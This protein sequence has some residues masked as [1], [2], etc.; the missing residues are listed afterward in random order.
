MEGG[1]G[2]SLPELPMTSNR[3]LVWICLTKQSW[4]W[5]GAGCGLVGPVLSAQ[6]CGAWLAFAL[7]DQNWQL[8]HW[9]PV[10]FTLSTRDRREGVW[11]SQGDHYAACNVVPHD[12]F[13]GG[14]VMVCQNV[15]EFSPLKVDDF[16]F[17]QTM[18]RPFI[19]NMIPSISINPH[20]AR[21]FFFS[22][23]SDVF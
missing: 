20:P 5:P 23:R 13:A 16:Y 2:L 9:H 11:R 14:L 12:R 6:H 4:G 10:R 7:K 19:P 21:F 17:H 15:F 8:H 3:L 1:T 22:L 18:G